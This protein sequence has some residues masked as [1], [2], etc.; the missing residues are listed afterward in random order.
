[1]IAKDKDGFNVD[2]LAILFTGNWLTVLAAPHLYRALQRA[3]EATHLVRLTDIWIAY[4]ERGDNYLASISDPDRDEQRPA[5]ARKLRDLLA[6]WTPPDLP[7]ENTEA[8]RALLH[9]EGAVPPRAA[10]AG[11]DSFNFDAGERS[12]ESYLAWPETEILPKETDAAEVEAAN[13]ERKM[14]V[15]NWLKNMR[16][17]GHG[18]G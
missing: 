17:S 8:A 16:V 9:A 1:M 2:T 18:T 7:A 4:T 13:L 6:A 10:E 5:L 11:W 14:S 12:L 3:V 15:A